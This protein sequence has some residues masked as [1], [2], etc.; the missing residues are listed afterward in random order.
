VPRKTIVY[1]GVA[2]TAST[3][4]GTSAL[5]RFAS[6]G[7]PPPFNPWFLIFTVGGRVYCASTSAA[8]CHDALHKMGYANTEQ[9]W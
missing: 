9:I 1:G 5:F 7:S 2:K 8:T 6:N 3:G 4:S